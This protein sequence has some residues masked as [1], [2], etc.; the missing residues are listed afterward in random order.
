LIARTRVLVHMR[1]ALRS[2][3]G[4]IFEFWAKSGR[5]GE[6][7]PMHS[8]PHHSLDVA[9]SAY[10]LLSPFRVPVSVPAPTLAALVAL[11]DIGKFTRPFQAKVQK[12]WPPALG[13]FE[14]PPPGP[15]HDDA[16]FALL[17]GV[18]ADR[19]DPLF[20]NWRLPST[21]QPLFRAVT[22]HHGR[23]PRETDSFEL[24]RAV[25][26]EICI[27]AASAFIDEALAVIDPPPLPPLG[28]ADRHRLTWFLAGLAVAADWLGSGRRWFVPVMAAE[29]TDLGRY[30]RELASSC[31]AIV[32]VHLQD[33][34]RCAF[35]S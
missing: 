16:G 29:N 9:A 6:T 12:L 32:A 4:L 25:A 26:C 24:P 13:A 34:G 30:W 23:P 18:L 2:I 15:P 22:G 17:C 7:A 33:H 20:I 19:L 11:H 27:E 5:E 35:S 1:N 8:V 3:M 31:A 21:R 10:V 28:D 14:T